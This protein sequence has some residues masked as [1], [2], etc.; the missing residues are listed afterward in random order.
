MTRSSIMR[1]QRQRG[2]TMME[3]LISLIVIAIGLLGLAGLQTKMVGVEMEAY[4]RSHAVI[5]LDDMMNR[6]RVDEANVRIGSYDDIG[7]DCSSFVPPAT[8]SSGFIC[9]WVKAIQGVAGSEDVGALI[10][11][12]GCLEVLADDPKT[13]RVSVAWQGMTPT[14]APANE[15]VCGADDYGNETLRRVVSGI[16]VLPPEEDE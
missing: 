2:F 13:I 5:L 12:Q 6:L 1:R 15:L 8:N 10:G 11:G 3:V 4:Q 9:E 16:V 7:G 14:V